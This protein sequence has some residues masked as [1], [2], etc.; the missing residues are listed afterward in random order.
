MIHRNC[1]VIDLF[2]TLIDSRPPMSDFSMLY[3]SMAQST[4]IPVPEC[5]KFLVPLLAQ[6]VLGR[7]LRINVAQ[8]IERASAANSVR[9]S[10]LE[11]FLW[12]EFGPIALAMSVPPGARRFLKWVRGEGVFVSLLSNCVLPE[13][14]MIQLLRDLSL[15]D[16][17]DAHHFSSSGIGAKPDPAFFST[18]VPG[19]I[20]AHDCLM[21]GDSLR[22]DI[23]P[24]RVLGFA[25]ARIRALQDWDDM[26]SP[27]WQTTRRWLHSTA[28]RR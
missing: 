11:E 5:R 6:G 23:E 24:A 21:I 27:V 14:Q 26:E 28:G 22:A 13:N 25:H 8:W 12:A 3:E 18:A 4:G 16:S 9:R 2:G 20:P 10:T 7:P 15:S 1:I 17:L 19:H